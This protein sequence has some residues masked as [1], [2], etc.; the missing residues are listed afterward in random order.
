[1]KKIKTFARYFLIENEK[2][3]RFG[4]VTFPKERGVSPVT[5]IFEGV[6][7]LSKNTIS[8]LFSVNSKLKMEMIAIKGGGV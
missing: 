6:F 5:E 2:S 3:I 1:M 7:F 4:T 8:A